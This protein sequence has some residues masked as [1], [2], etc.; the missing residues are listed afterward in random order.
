MGDV[1]DLDPLEARL[2]ERLAGLRAAHGLSLDALAA[3]TGISRATLSRVERGETSPT[4]TML[5]RLCA[6]YGWTLSRL[7]AAAEEAPPAL[8][9]GPE[10]PAWTDPETGFRRRL[11]SPPGP[12]LTLELTR[13]H[14][15]PGAA[16]A[17]PAPPFARMEQ[18]LLLLEGA[19]EFSHDTE[20]W[21]LAP[22]DCLRLRLTGPTRLA[23]GPAGADY[24][25]AIAGTAP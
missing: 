1:L 6:A 5:G 15:P 13:C 3:R 4:A 22:G 7:M 25:L 2:A 18:H 20:T 8:I 21:R 19:L 12:G 24:L 11:A 9:R 23:G 17:Y 16:L 14:L 10:Q